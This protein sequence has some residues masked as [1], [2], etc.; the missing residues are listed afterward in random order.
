MQLYWSS[1]SP[2]ARKV[3]VAAHELGLADGIRLVPVTVTPF[4]PE[5]SLAAANPLLKIPTLVPD[6]GPPIHD[7]GVICEYLDGLQGE[8][9][10]FPAAGP[11]RIRALTLQATGDGLMEVL[12]F[13]L[14]LRSRFE[15]PH[16][17]ALAQAS[18]LKLRQTLDM[19][20]AAVAELDTPQPHIGAIAVGVALGYADFR[21]DTEQWREGRPGLAAWYTRFAER[22]SMRATGPQD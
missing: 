18:R 15:G 16:I 20:E 13:W 7:S 1:R 22:P 10:L 11:Q 19:L 21:F 17:D 3:L 12:V 5:P 4:V 9:R 6:T 8:H 14:T 2:F